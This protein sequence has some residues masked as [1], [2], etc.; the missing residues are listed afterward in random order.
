MSKYIGV[1][2]GTA[3]PPPVPAG[4]QTPIEQGIGRADTG[5]DLESIGTTG[6]KVEHN[7]RQPNFVSSRQQQSVKLQA[8]SQSYVRDDVTTLDRKFATGIWA[9]MCRL[10]EHKQTL[11]DRGWEYYERITL[12]RYKVGGG[13]MRLAEKG[14]TEVQTRIYPLF[15]CSM[16]MFSDFGIS[17]SLYFSTLL[18]L[19][20][21]LAVAAAMNVP[22]IMMFEGDSWSDGQQTLRSSSALGDLALIGSAYCDQTAYVECDNCDVSKFK[23]TR[24]VESATSPGTYFYLTNT[25]QITIDA[26]LVDFATVLFLF[27]SIILMGWYQRKLAVRFDEKVQTA[28]D[29]SLTVHDPCEDAIDPDEWADFFSRFGEVA[30]I[31]VALDNQTLVSLLCEQR[32]LRLEISLQLKENSSYDEEI[33]F[34]NEEEPGCFEKLANGINLMKGLPL[35][36]KELIAVQGKLWEEIERVSKSGGYPTTKVFVTFEHEEGQRKAL[37]ALSTGLIAAWTDTSKNIP[38]T[39]CFRSKNVLKVEES[40]EPSATRWPEVH[41]STKK[42]YQERLLSWTLTL[43]AIIGAGFSVY[44]IEKINTIVAAGFISL[45]NTL[46][47]MLCSFFNSLESHASEG[48]AQESLYMK[49]AFARWTNTAIVICVITPFTATLNGVN[50]DVDNFV[51]V[52][53]ELLFQVYTVLFAD[54]VSYPIY[55][56]LD[57]GGVL[58]KFFLAPFAKNQAV[59]NNYFQGTAWSVAER[60]TDIT[61]TMFLAFFYA[62]IFP[63]SYIFC[64]AS[65][66][67]NFLVDR[68]C[69]LRLWK[70]HPATGT[71]VATI[72]LKF[73]LVTVLAHSVMSAYWWSGFPFDNL[74]LTLDGGEGGAASQTVQTTLGQVVTASGTYSYCDQDLLKNW[75]FPALPEFQ[76]EHQWMTSE[77]AT[78][79]SITGIASAVFVGLIFFGFFGS[80]IFFSVKHLFVP[81]YKESGQD[82]NIPFSCCRGE[83]SSHIPE[84]KVAGFDHPFIATSLDNLDLDLQLSWNP[85]KN[86]TFHDWCL[87]SDEDLGDLVPKNAPRTRSKLFAQTKY[88]PPN[89]MGVYKIREI[90]NLTD[91]EDASK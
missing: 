11:Y 58:N 30:C 51:I 33:G 43:A 35:L 22:N 31:T 28:A 91:G 42:K 80:G 81:A 68:Y 72:S 52:K 47:P 26:V 90:D 17:V 88:Y 13:K 40:K 45:Y 38:V 14:E 86:E 79:V 56:I 24:Y 75:K 2:T 39:Q 55:R 34:L 85:T 84:Y 49:I 20:I 6:T 61:K 69:I 7:L 12:P 53:S 8:P 65:L 67:F 29:Y 54:V 15:D 16:S 87:C 46:I 5:N 64:L 18:I 3:L 37:N 62:A 10:D 78:L 44:G 66:I 60:Y 73:M 82:Q 70:S 63:T 89:E 9:K 83:I 4:K 77:Q 21:I 25:C 1:Q 19:S 32:R 50:L 48:G 74:C 59:I 23:D 57:F 71:Q 36:H 41:I 27:I 76:G